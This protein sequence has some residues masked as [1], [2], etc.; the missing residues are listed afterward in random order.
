MPPSTATTPG[1]HI[2]PTDPASYIP[3]T[4]QQLDTSSSLSLTSASRDLLQAAWANTAG[5]L[6]HRNTANST[7]PTDDKGKNVNSNQ[8]NN[9]N[10]PAPNNDEGE[11]QQHTPQRATGPSGSLNTPPSAAGR[12]PSTPVSCTPTEHKQ[13][14][15]TTAAAAQGGRSRITWDTEEVVT[16]RAAPGSSP[17]S[18]PTTWGQRVQPPLSPAAHA[19]RVNHQVTTDHTGRLSAPARGLSSPRGGN[20]RSSNHRGSTPDDSSADSSDGEFASA[21]SSG[22]LTSRF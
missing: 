1:P 7:T 2:C 5:R 15:T 12:P 3:P 21:T 4:L 20:G 19:T 9:N 13:H 18:S 10:T 11:R 16:Q 6:F 22:T 14:T 8:H 17:S